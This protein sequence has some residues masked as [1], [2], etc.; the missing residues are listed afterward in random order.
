M[1]NRS[2]KLIKNG[3]LFLFGARGTGKSTLIR[4]HFEDE[5]TLWIDLLTEA[6]E[7]RF[8]RHPDQLSFHLANQRYDYVVIDEIQKFPKLLDIV[9]AEIEKKIRPIL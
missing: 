4:K 8:G 1:V 2:Q 7:Y 6:D 5:K 3:N 9:H